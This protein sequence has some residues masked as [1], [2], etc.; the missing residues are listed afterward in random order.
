VPALLVGGGLVG[1]G[2]VSLSELGFRR[3]RIASELLLGLAALI[4]CLACYYLIVRS[5]M[6]DAQ[7]VFEA[8]AAQPLG[9]RALLLAPVVDLRGP[10][11]MA[12]C[13]H[14]RP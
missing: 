11:A 2:S 3:D 13:G 9:E 1:I 14:S 12:F 8:I 4:A 10:R 5:L 6:P 7:R